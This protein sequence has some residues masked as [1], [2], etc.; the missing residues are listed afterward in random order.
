[1]TLILLQSAVVYIPLQLFGPPINPLLLT[2]GEGDMNI[3]HCQSKLC[4]IEYG[5]N[6]KVT[7]S[8]GSLDMDTCRLGYT[9]EEKKNV[10][11]ISLCYYVTT[12][13]LTAAL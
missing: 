3:R 10:N 1:M 12:L 9:V 11:A 2:R 5:S 7:I 13:V 8:G 6:G 4:C